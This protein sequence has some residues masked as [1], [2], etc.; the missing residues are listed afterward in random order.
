MVL[1][2]KGTPRNQTK[3]GPLLHNVQSY[4][5]LIF[6][7]K[8]E[9]P[10]MDSFMHLHMFSLPCYMPG[11]VLDPGDTTVTKIDNVPGFVGLYSDGIMLMR[12][13]GNRRESDYYFTRGSALVWLSLGEHVKSE[14]GSQSLCQISQEIVPIWPQ[15]L[16][17]WGRELPNGKV[18]SRDL[19]Q[20][21][22]PPH[23]QPRARSPLLS[24]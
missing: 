21:S 16:C 18:G 9:N 12:L 13:W 10:F 2:V 8:F 5:L 17:F 4:A 22:S 20:A 15:T 14:C 11:A 23:P 3:S 1:P 6:L 7:F 24:Y 19:I